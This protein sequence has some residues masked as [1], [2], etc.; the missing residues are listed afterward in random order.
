M[1]YQAH[2]NKYSD[3]KGIST[4]TEVHFEVLYQLKITSGTHQIFYLTRCLI[5]SDSSTPLFFQQ[6]VFPSYHWTKTARRK[7]IAEMLRFFCLFFYLYACL[8]TG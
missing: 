1:T 2:S 5:D 6:F 4:V 3:L 8:D 7:K